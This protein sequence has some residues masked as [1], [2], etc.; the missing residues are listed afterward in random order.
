MA[1]ASRNIHNPRRC[2]D[3]VRARGREMLPEV[4]E[5]TAI[6][7]GTSARP[8]SPHFVA[9]IKKT[10]YGPRERMLLRSMPYHMRDSCRYNNDVL[11]SV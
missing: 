8:A 4:H 11:K 3:G 7:A 1:V 6:V 9:P 2:A 5:Q 10:D